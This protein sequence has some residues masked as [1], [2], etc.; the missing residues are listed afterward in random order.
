MTV[1]CLSRRRAAGDERP[2]HDA[3]AIDRCEMQPL[4]TGRVMVLLEFI[5]GWIERTKGMAEEAMIGVGRRRCRVGADVVR[6][7]VVRNRN[8]DARDVRLVFM[9]RREAARAKA[10]EQ[11]KRD[12]GT[13]DPRGTAEH[14]NQLNDTRCTPSSTWQ[15]VGLCQSEN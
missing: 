13:L 12:T 11:Q 4:G 14:Q 15:I 6:A 8:R 7:F 3:V 1:R 10:G 2:R 5:E 9:R